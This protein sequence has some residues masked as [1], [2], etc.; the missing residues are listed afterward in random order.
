MPLGT[1]RIIAWK[2]SGGKDTLQL[3][4]GCLAQFFCNWNSKGEKWRW[5]SDIFSMEQTNVTEGNNDKT[6]ITSPLPSFVVGGWSPNEKDIAREES[7][8]SSQL[9]YLKPAFNQTTHTTNWSVEAW[10]RP[11]SRWAMP[12]ESSGPRLSALIC[13]GCGGSGIEDPLCLSKRHMPFPFWPFVFLR[14]G[15]LSTSGMEATELIRVQWRT[16]KVIPLGSHDPM[17]LKLHRNAI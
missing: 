13:M 1:T 9:L 17:A 7:D 16:I 14:H 10:T 5:A 11:K 8:F 12:D 15:R 4:V 3:P 6:T 2:R